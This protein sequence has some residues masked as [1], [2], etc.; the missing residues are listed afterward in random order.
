MKPIAPD[1]MPGHVFITLAKD[2]PEYQPLSVLIGPKPEQPMVCEF[3]FE[4]AELL[5]VLGPGARIRITQL[6]FGERFHPIRVE[7]VESVNHYYVR[8]KEKKTMEVEAGEAT[9][10][11]GEAPQ[12]QGEPGQGGA[13]GGAEPCETPLAPD[14]TTDTGATTAPEKGE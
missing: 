3:E 12:T 7:V 5:R 10:G 14:P 1:P 13:P 11:A 9:G 6:T 2:Q 8:Q 4:G